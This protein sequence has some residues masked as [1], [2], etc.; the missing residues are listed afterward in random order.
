MSVQISGYYGKQVKVRGLFASHSSQR[1]AE[2]TAFQR[3]YEK[4]TGSIRKDGIIEDKKTEICILA[5]TVIIY[6]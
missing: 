6:K 1:T 5:E 2:P 4:K 3:I